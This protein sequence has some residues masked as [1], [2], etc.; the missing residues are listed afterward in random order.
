MR[1]N[2]LSVIGAL[3]LLLVAGGTFANEGHAGW[4]REAENEVANLP[5]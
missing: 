3:A 5:A 1:T 4:Q 2:N